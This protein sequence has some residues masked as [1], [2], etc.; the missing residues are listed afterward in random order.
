M[1]CPRGRA[2]TDRT[3]ARSPPT[4]AP[5]GACACSASSGLTTVPAFSRSAAA[6]ALL[7]AAASSFYVHPGRLRLGCDVCARM[8]TA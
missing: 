7:E 1:G 2:A 5:A 3:R 4:S 8:K 6:T